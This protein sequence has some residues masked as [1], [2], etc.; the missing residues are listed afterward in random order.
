M[1]AS[2]ST[3]KPKI[4]FAIAPRVVRLESSDG[5]VT[6]PPSQQQGSVLHALAQ[7]QPD[8]VGVGHASL[9]DHEGIT[10]SSSASEVER[11]GG[12]NRD[13]PGSTGLPRDR[14]TQ[15]RE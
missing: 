9:E 8:L 14:E 15:S 10:R 11:Q 4:T 3:L 5:P 12:G 2:A 7:Q 1:I 6:A 13:R